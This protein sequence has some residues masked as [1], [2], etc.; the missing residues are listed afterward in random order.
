[1]LNPPNRVS[2]AWW[3]VKD[4]SQQNKGLRSGK[5]TKERYREHG[6][7]GGSEGAEEGVRVRWTL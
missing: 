6:K 7:S 4:V 3:T 5:G 1:M 2:P